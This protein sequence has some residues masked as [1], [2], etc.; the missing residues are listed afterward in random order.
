MKTERNCKED[1][2]LAVFLLLF[3]FFTSRFG[4]LRFGSGVSD[5]YGDVA[6]FDSG[7]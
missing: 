3:F 5:L 1:R 2:P 6:I 4:S 7:F